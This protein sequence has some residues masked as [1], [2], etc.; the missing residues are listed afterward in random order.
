MAM[1]SAITTATIAYES[2][3]TSRGS[4]RAKP[5]LTISQYRGLEHEAAGGDVCAGRYRLL[6]AGHQP[7]ER[8]HASGSLR[9]H[10]RDAA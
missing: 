4:G 1:H 5:R 7:A 8:V 9:T 3:R 6:R 2:Q 10:A